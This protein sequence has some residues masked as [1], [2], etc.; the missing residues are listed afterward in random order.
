[1][2]TSTLTPEAQS[3]AISPGVSASVRIYALD[4]FV[5]TGT[6][7]RIAMSLNATTRTMRAD[8]RRG[9]KHNGDDGGDNGCGVGDGAT[10]P[11][12]LSHKHKARPLQLK[13][14]GT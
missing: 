6:V 5:A 13:C 2:T 1:M 7:T 8:G 4:S 11:P 12:P 10:W 3:A 9:G 14:S